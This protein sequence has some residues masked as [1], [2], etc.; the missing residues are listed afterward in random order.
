M[1]EENMVKKASEQFYAGLNRMANGDASSLADIWSHDATVSAMHPIGG[2]TIGW[3]KVQESWEQV[4]GLASTGK[5]QLE[6][7]IIHVIGEMAYE[8][9]TERGKFDLAGQPVSLELR[10]TNLYRREDD[11]WK[12]IHHHTDLSPAMI[13]IIDHLPVKT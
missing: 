1:S 12:I 6:N 4:A 13:E 2:Q 8:L 10:V 5:I 11:G 3:D 9:G 7:Q